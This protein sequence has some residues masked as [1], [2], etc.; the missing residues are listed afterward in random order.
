MVDHTYKNKIDHAATRSVRTNPD[1]KIYKKVWREDTSRK[2]KEIMDD[3]MSNFYSSGNQFG[4]LLALELV[5]KLG[6]WMAENDITPADV[7]K[8]VG[9]VETRRWRHT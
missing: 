4:G 9:D 6:I 8:I 5:G 7:R 2:D 1:L 3:S